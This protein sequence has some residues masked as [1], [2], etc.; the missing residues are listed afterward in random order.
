MRAA[1]LLYIWRTL[2]KLAFDSSQSLIQRRD[3]ATQV[4]SDEAF[5]TGPIA[6][7]IV[8]N[9]FG[10]ILEASHQLVLR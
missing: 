2:C 8:K 5:T 6:D 4:H 10:T 9:D 3:R 7:P 1:F